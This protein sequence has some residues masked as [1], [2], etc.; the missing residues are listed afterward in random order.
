MLFVIFLSDSVYKFLYF[1]S[2]DDKA[3]DALFD[4]PLTKGQVS[5]ALSVSI[6]GE[7][8]NYNQF[9]FTGEIDKLVAMT[10]LINVPFI[11]PIALPDYTKISDVIQ[12]AWRSI[13]AQWADVTVEVRAQEEFLDEDGQFVHGLL[14]SVRK[15]SKILA[16]E[17]LP[18][19]PEDALDGVELITGP[20]GPYKLSKVVIGELRRYKLAMHIFLDKWVS[21]DDQVKVALTLQNMIKG[22]RA[23]KCTRDISSRKLQLEYCMY[24]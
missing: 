4:A 19:L 15:S 11:M 20:S 8:G 5:T 16:L 13:G 7:T 24:N 22:V 21:F 10:E 14:Y 1:V 17:D 6:T 18:D 9:M 23:G 3:V 12:A 2:A